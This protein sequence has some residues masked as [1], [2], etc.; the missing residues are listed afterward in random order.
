MDGDG[1]WK[2]VEGKMR[3]RE[4][5]EEGGKTRVTLQNPTIHEREGLV[6]Q[7]EDIAKSK[8]TKQ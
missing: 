5:G 2:E 8:N 7:I 4:G 1:P 6:V 3:E